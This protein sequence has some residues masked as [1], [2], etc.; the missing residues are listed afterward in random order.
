MKKLVKFLS[1]ILIVLGFN[2]NAQEFVRVNQM[3]YLT[4]SP[5]IAIASSLNTSDFEIKDAKSD[6]TVFKGT[7]SESKFWSQ[8]NENLQTIDFSDFKEEGEYYID[9]NGEKSYN[10][11][12]KKEG[13][14]HDLSVWTIKAFYLWRSSIAIDSMYASLGK[15]NFARDLGHPDTMVFIHSSAATEERRAESIISSPKGWYDAG[16][17]NKYVVN[18]GITLHNMLLAYE[19]FPEYYNNLSLN[20]PESGNGLPDLLNE[21]KWEVDWLFTMQ[22]PFDGGVYHKLTTKRFCGMVQPADDDL[23]RYVVKKSTASTLDFVAEMAIVARVFKHI[24]KDL[25][26]RALKVAEYA[27]EWAK[28]NPKILFNNPEGIRTGS[29]ADM[30]VEDEWFW[31]ASEMFITTKQSKYYQELDFFQK[32]E[33]PNWSKVNTLGLISLRVHLND[34]A[35]CADKNMISRKFFTLVN[36]LYNQ[37]KYSSGK[38]AL[39]KF[40][41]GSNGDIAEIGVIFGVAYLM[42][43]DAKFADGMLGHFNYLLGCNPTAYSFVTQFGDKYPENLHDR[44][45]SSDN[46]DYPLP[47]YVCGGANPNQISDCGR[48]N[49]PSLAPARC[50]LDE[51]CSYSTNEIAINWNAPMVLLTGMVNNIFEKK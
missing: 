30:N 9:V 18:A 5:K 6:K 34:L 14:F 51:V 41:W 26:K 44:R 25:S 12:I 4:E 49:Y 3:G 19:L 24:D 1:P 42:E 33:F 13:L 48:N 35:E 15:Y 39:K 23:D 10:F 36:G 17:Y 2:L 43:N 40:E 50:Y 8:S 47:G 38:L 46:Y 32:F 37:F 16:D 21:I 27:W 45:M 11:E 7:L 31:A 29:Y 22:D 20:I 28:K